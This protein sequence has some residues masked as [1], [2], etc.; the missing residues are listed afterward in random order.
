M[1]KL[2]LSLLLASACTASR[3]APTPPKPPVAAE[4][5]GS[6]LVLGTVGDVLVA[7]YPPKGFDAL[8]IRERLLAWHLAQAAW[9]GDELYFMQT[10]KY[11]LPIKR[12]LEQIL[13]EVE[14]LPEGTGEKLR[15]Y[16]RMLYLHHGIHDGRTGNK[17]LPPFTR[18]EFDAAA[19]VAKV[20]VSEELLAA[21]FDPAVAP[22]QT[23]KTPGEGKDPIVESAANH[24]EGVTSEDLANYTDEYELNSRIARVDGELVETPYRAGGLGA[25]PGLG[26][27]QLEKVIGHLE[28]AL[29]YATEAQK[30]AL[31]HLV[32]YFRTGDNRHFTD[33]DIAWVKQVFP[34]DYI[35]GFIETYTDVRGRKGS[36]EA[37]VAIR[38]PERDPP[39]QRM[40][41]E[42][43]YFEERLPWD[44][45][46][47]RT[48][49]NPPAAAAI[50]VLAATGDAGPF[51]FLGVNL[52]NAQ[53][54][55]EEYGS[56]NFV[57]LSVNDVR[58]EL[59]S[60][61]TLREF[62]PAE[63]LETVLRCAPHYEYVTTG[64]HEIT[65][66]GSGKVS[67]DLPASPRTLLAPYYST[68]EEGRA[69]LVG[70]FLIF[71]E[72]VLE[73]GL[74]PDAECQQAYPQ[75]KS[76]LDFV[77]LKQMPEGETA[78]GDHL[79]AA[80]IA[81]GRLEEAGAVVF[82]RRD[83]KLFPVVKDPAAWRR[84]VGELLAELQR[85]KATGDKPALA[86]LVEKHGTKLDVGRRDEVVARVGA[87][88]LPR[89]IATIPP[90][91]TP[92]TDE[93]GRVVDVRAAQTTDLDAYFDLLQRAAP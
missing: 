68:L 58:D 80:L 63:S 50:T 5:G 28:A 8:P 54:L 34:V 91:L 35:L 92:V 31:K 88:G 56:K 72:K 83:G 76:V 45:A 67:P 74:L 30:T 86:A 47:K 71:D 12:L 78:E 59:V 93:A 62:V 43:P 44:E 65:G 40:A 22:V 16:R 36:F 13:T 25:E 4:G 82:E 73:L 79:R 49:F 81:Q 20:S 23:N 61:P 24:Y 7:S 33:H 39:L 89:V 37:F 41:R 87:L 19:E 60:V 11:A 21:M 90:M 48:D 46:W 53:W 57:N 15:E 1:R 26:A 51:T 27:A 70:D 75:Y 17:F 9:A 32:T 69:E 2:L 64:F 38:D 85:I 18:E 14:A 52:P 3:P 6:T 42:A 10:S 84:T 29:P 66:H 55:R 77:R